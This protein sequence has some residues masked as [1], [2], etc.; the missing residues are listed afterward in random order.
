MTQEAGMLAPRDAYGEA[1]V[2][3]GKINPDVVVLDADVGTS[4][5]S[6]CF[7]EA[8]PER[9]FQV[10]IAEQNMMGIAAGLATMGLIPYACTFAVFAVPLK[11]NFCLMC[12]RIK[13]ALYEA[14]DFILVTSLYQP[15]IPVT[16]RVPRESSNAPYFSQ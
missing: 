9:F 15:S 12:I 1:L 14:N 5:K 13:R 8:F 4:T 16:P 11:S 2:E 7:K 10:G 3:L 6:I